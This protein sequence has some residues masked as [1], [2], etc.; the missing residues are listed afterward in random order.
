MSAFGFNAKYIGRSSLARSLAQ[1]IES[2]LFLLLG[3]P[4]LVIHFSLEM[5]PRIDGSPVEDMVT[6]V[7]EHEFR[8][9]AQMRPGHAARQ[10]RVARC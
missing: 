9:M 1:T 4:K 6:G 7:S 2:S 8:K 3:E 10:L 5:V